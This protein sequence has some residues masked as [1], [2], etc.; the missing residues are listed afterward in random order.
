MVIIM[1]KTVM[2]IVMLFAALLVGCGETA[3]S[4][5]AAPP[6]TSNGGS[7]LS[8]TAA[9]PT[10][11][12]PALPDGFQFETAGVTIRM[13]ENASPVVAALGEPLRLF[14]A[15]SC[16]FE[17]IDR[18][19]YFSGFE[20]FTFPVDGEDFILSL[21]FTDD[22]VTTCMGVYLGQSLDDV[23][24]AYGEDFVQNYGQYTYT[25]GHSTLSFLIENDEIVVIIYNFTNAPA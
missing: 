19:Y 25:R 16:A 6:P 7:V 17:G 8:P 4:E 10:G 1:R 18:I 2:F 23:I 13:G 24:A 9:S 14:E 22:S 3:P 20:L 5:S 11:A 12:A 15:P 21:N